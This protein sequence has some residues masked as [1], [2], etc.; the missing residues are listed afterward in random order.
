MAELVRRAIDTVYRPKTRP[1][2]RGYEMQV[3]VF[4]APDA[5][6]VG[7]LATVPRRVTD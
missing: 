5:A 4:R 7:R 3:A 2:V 6:T 1:V